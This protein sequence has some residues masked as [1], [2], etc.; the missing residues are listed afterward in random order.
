MHKQTDLVVKSIFYYLNID[1]IVKEKMSSK[2]RAS[3][4]GILTK[5]RD[6]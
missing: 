5:K 4:Q 6:I 1:K 3:I 2:A